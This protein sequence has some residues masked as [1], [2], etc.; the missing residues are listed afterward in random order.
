M[1]EKDAKITGDGFTLLEVLLVIAILS[2]IMYSI[3]LTFTST[4]SSISYVEKVANI[5]Q[6]GR[7][8]MRIFA[9]EVSSAYLISQSYITKE[10]QNLNNPTFLIGINDS[11][12]GKE[13]DKIIFTSMAHRIVVISKD[14]NSGK[15]PVNQSEHAVISYFVDSSEPGV[16]FRFDAPLFVTVESAELFGGSLPSNL[17]SYRY[18]L[19]ENVSELSLQYFDWI[20]RTWSDD[21]DST[22]TNRLP[23][24]VKITLVLSDESGNTEHFFNLIDVPR[25]MR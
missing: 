11:Y 24:L 18:P 5:K 6:Q 13:M 9:R 3:Y 17:N 19:L 1:N 22:K 2:A 10:G 21:W 8:F 23:G 14:A 25:G 12:E 15:L 20:S 7:A 16:L 4:L